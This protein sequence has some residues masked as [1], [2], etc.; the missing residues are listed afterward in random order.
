ME[1][2][3]LNIQVVDRY[4]EVGSFRSYLQLVKPRPVTQRLRER[5]RTG[6]AALIPAYGQLAG[7]VRV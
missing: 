5:V 3:R 2:W 1:T 7:R 4:T 6:P